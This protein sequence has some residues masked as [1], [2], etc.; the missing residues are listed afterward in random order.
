MA[1]PAARISDA[2]RVKLL[3]L[4]AWLR[5]RLKSSPQVEDVHVRA[6]P[7]VI[8]EIPANMVWIFIDHDV[9]AVPEP[10]AA[11]D[12]VVWGDA[13]EEAAK[14]ETARPAALN[15]ED[16]AFAKTAPEASVRPRAIQVVV[17][18]IPARIMSNPPVVGVDVGHVGM[19]RFVFEVVIL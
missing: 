17:G 8:R 18:I 13:E 16:M 7:D 9:V 12:N 3:P 5:L 4:Q 6:Q 10:I 1:L 19:S 15:P 14:P 11:I 2:C